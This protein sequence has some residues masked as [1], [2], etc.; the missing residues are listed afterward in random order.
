[1]VQFHLF[2]PLWSHPL[3]LDRKHYTQSSPFS[4]GDWEL[5]ASDSQR[6]AK[7]STHQLIIHGAFKVCVVAL[8]HHG[9]CWLSFHTMVAYHIWRA[10]NAVTEEDHH[11]AEKYFLL[12]K[13]W[14]CCHIWK[15][16]C[17]C[18]H[19]CMNTCM[20]MRSRK[21]P[22]CA[23]NVLYQPYTVTVMCGLFC[24]SRGCCEKRSIS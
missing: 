24:L 23:V 4:R 6:N 8:C 14:W 17:M 12:L 20:E 16:Q 10:Y 15:E 1:M 13:I 22:Y 11:G 2:R 3:V 19:V 9:N 7:V 5:K 21:H 18:A